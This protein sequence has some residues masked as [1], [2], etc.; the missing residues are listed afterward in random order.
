MDESFGKDQYRDA[1]AGP[2][3]SM[4]A[5]LREGFGR[6]VEEGLYGEQVDPFHGRGALVGK[7]GSGGLEDHLVDAGRGVDP[8]MG[9][10]FEEYAQESAAERFRLLE[11]G[12]SRNRSAGR[13]LG[14][15]D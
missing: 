5:R 8:I 13:S 10:G 4:A 6:M 1:G 7:D 14:E 9:R 11:E 12:R 2:L 3:M 15:S